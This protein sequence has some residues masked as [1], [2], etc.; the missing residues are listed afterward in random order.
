MK[1]KH[2]STEEI[3]MFNLPDC[4]LD[5]DNEGDFNCDSDVE[6]YSVEAHLYFLNDVFPSLIC[7][8]LS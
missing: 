7:C 8:S 1:R 5:N 3:N 6:L 2:L 4:V